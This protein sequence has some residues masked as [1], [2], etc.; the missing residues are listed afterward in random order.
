MKIRH[1]L[2]LMVLLWAAL[3][4][5]NNEDKILMTRWGVEYYNVLRISSFDVTTPQNQPTFFTLTIT[6]NTDEEI[7]RPYMNYQLHWN[8]EILIDTKSRYRRTIRGREQFSITNRDIFSRAGSPM[9]HSPKPSI[10]ISKILDRKLP[11]LRDT[12]LKT[13]LFPDGRYTFTAWFTSDEAGT[14]KISGELEPFTFTVRNPGGLFLI[15]PGT[16]LGSISIPTVSSTPVSFRWSSNLVGSNTFKLLVKEFED[17][18]MLNPSFI[19]IGG[20]V[21]ID[22]DVEEG[23]SF[24]SDFIDLKEGRYYAWQ[25]STELVDPTSR[26]QPVI[27]SPFYVFRYSTS[28]DDTQEDNIKNIEL[29]LMNLNIPELIKL[30]AEGYR[31]TGVIEHNGQVFS[32]GQIQAVLQDLLSREIIRVDIVD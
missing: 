25:V 26:T 12:V 14:N 16:A 24:F 2:I 5:A 30:I 19:E 23:K 21:I 10:D 18:T 3:L 27:K 6:N 15:A 11:H 31:P 7:E 13:G 4:S 1:L 32:E 20:N 22:E 29:F 9:F 28:T 8:N 17:T